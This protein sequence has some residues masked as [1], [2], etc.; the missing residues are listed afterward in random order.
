[1]IGLSYQITQIFRI[2]PY[3]KKE[4]QHYHIN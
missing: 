2:W 4:Y 3:C 1:M